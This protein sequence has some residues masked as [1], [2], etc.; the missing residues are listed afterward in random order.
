MDDFLKK[1][2]T[3]FDTPSPPCPFFGKI[4]CNFFQESMTKIF[5]QHQTPICKHAWYHYFM[6][7]EGAWWWF[8]HSRAALRYLC[9]FFPVA[10][11]WPE[12]SHY[13]PTCFTSVWVRAVLVKCL[14][15]I[16]TAKKVTKEVKKWELKAIL[17]P[18][19]GQGVTLWRWDSYNMNF[20]GTHDL[21]RFWA[22]LDV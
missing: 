21:V 8:D 15:V 2:Q 6:S 10:I 20:N 16:L 22:L 17:W 7:R 9:Y 11:F 5:D 1:L 18:F 4:Y 14:N 19:L 13:H 3:A 12:T